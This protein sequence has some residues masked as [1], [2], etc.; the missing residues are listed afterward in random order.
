MRLRERPVFRS[1]RAFER[2]IGRTVAPLDFF[3]HFLS[4]SFLI[5]R[6]EQSF[7]PIFQKRSKESVNYHWTY[8]PIVLLFCCLTRGIC[9]HSLAWGLRRL[10]ADKVEYNW[11]VVLYANESGRSGH[12]CCRCL[13]GMLSWWQVWMWSF[14][15]VELVFLWTIRCNLW[16]PRDRPDILRDSAICIVLQSFWEK[17]MW[18][19]WRVNDWL[20]CRRR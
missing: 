3:C 10:V 17:V 12:C 16:D 6:L 20:Y 9:N 13:S 14:S 1:P 15:F 7:Y 11:P 4:N 2:F 5:N 8:W 19:V 18:Q